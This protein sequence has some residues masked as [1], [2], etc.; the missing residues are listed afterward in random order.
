MGKNASIGLKNANESSLTQGITANHDQCKTITPY[1]TSVFTY[2]LPLFSGP[3]PTISPRF[4]SFQILDGV[5]FMI[6]ICYALPQSPPI[7]AQPLAFSYL[8]SRSSFFSPET[9]TKSR[10]I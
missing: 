9:C 2:N 1:F 3:L 8:N 4:G 10:Y 6:F 5:G 7:A